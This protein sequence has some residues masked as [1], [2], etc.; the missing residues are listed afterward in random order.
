[1]FHW[2]YPANVKIYDVLGAFRE[3]YAFWPINSKV[4]IGDVVYIYLSAPYKQIGFVCHVNEINLIENQVIEKTSPYFRGN[5]NK[6][7]NDKTFMKLT[8]TSK[9]E[10]EENSLLSYTNLK[11]NGLNGAFM[12]PRKLENNPKLWKY[13]QGVF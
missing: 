1:M 8:T 13:I 11:K 5:T 12:G 4:S 9:I 2:V 10:L 3:P 7:K 6:T